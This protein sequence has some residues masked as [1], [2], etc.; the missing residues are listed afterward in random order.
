[1][2]GSRGT[3]LWSL[4]PEPIECVP[5]IPME[6]SRPFYFSDP[7]AVTNEG[8]GSRLVSVMDENSNRY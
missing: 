5:P 1:M 2:G 8:G 3:A 6:D 4:L 7:H